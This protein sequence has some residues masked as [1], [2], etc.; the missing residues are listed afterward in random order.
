MNQ[1]R[2]RRLNNAHNTKQDQCSI[3]TDNLAVILVDPLHKCIADLFQRH[4]LIQI[5]RTDGDICNLFCNLST[6]ADGDSR[7]RRRKCR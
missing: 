6:I 1:R 5:L 2:H 4:D 3:D 7:I